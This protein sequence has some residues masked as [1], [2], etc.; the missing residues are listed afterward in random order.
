MSW[1]GCARQLEVSS[2]AQAELRGEDQQLRAALADLDARVL[3]TEAQLSAL[4]GRDVGDALVRYETL[5]EKGRGQ[6][7]LLAERRRG[8]D[9]ELTVVGR[10]GGDRLARVRAGP[11]ARR[12]RAGRTGRRVRHR[13]RRRTSWP[14]PR[15]SL[16]EERQRFEADWGEGVPGPHR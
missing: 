4:G 10:R 15:A 9:R 1:R 7:A 16:A 11:A 5:R 2:R 13:A 3:A 8:V 12:G 14:R 6:L